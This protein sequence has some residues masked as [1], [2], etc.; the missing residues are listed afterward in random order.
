MT[1]V[2]MI[3]ATVNVYSTPSFGSFSGSVVYTEGDGSPQLS[4]IEIK[5]YSATPIYD[6]DTGDLL[7]FG[8]TYEFSVYTNSEGEFSFSKPSQYCSVSANLASIPD[9]YGLSKETQFIVPER[10]TTVYNISSIAD[11]EIDVSSG[12]P[13]PEIFNA[14]GDTILAHYYVTNTLSN[15]S[16]AQLATSL[17]SVNRLAADTESG[18]INVSGTNYPYTVSV[19]MSEM[20]TL[21]KVDYLFSKEKITKAQQVQFY[22]DMILNSAQYDFEG[23]GTMMLATVR[24]YYGAN[25]KAWQN[26][27]LYSVLSEESEADAYITRT[28]AL[29][30]NSNFVFRVYYDSAAMNMNYVNSFVNVCET[31]VRNFLIE[32]GFE[33]PNYYCDSYT[34]NYVPGTPYE[35][36]LSINSP[37]LIAPGVTYPDWGIGSKIYISY[38][39]VN[40]EVIEN[41]VAHEFAHAILCRYGISTTDNMWIHESFASMFAFVNC[42]GHSEFADMVSGYYNNIHISIY[43]NPNTN[44]ALVYPL[45]I[46]KNFGGWDTIKTVLEGYSSYQNIFLSITAALEEQNSSYQD[47]FLR[48]AMNN[49]KPSVFYDDFVV[50]DPLSGKV[51]GTAVKASEEIE[52]SDLVATN[53]D[54]N[55]MAAAYRKFTSEINVGS[56]YFTIEITSAATDKLYLGSVKEGPNDYTMGFVHVTAGFSRYTLWQSNFGDAVDTYTVVLANTNTNTTDNPISFLVTTSGD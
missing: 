3:A 31:V 13:V 48:C 42:G 51:W 11:V 41:M 54:V 56:A 24:D 34:P 53:G 21:G 32:Y 49:V 29:P 33:A 27:R 28:V 44:G 4:G 6:T 55:S 18:F 30:N 14:A 25:T 15:T 52:Y 5:V 7:Y 37:L 22:E 16:N 26:S 19:D 45:T 10:T 1:V 20:S 36:Y 9:G 43:N 39:Y 47:V 46:Y 23:C 38:S 50:E 12:S 8:E 40:N 17:Q 35:F 2:M